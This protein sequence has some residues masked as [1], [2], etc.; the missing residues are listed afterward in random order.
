[1]FA[2]HEAVLAVCFPVARDRL[3]GLTHDGGLGHTS[4][5]A[6]ADGLAWLTRAGPPGT[7][8]SL[9]RLVR[10]SVLEPVPRADEMV[11]PLRWEAIGAGGPPFPVLDANL[12]L[13]RCPSERT[14]LVLTG[15]YRSPLGA[16]AAPLDRSVLGRAATATVRSLLARIAESLA[17]R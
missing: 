10:V 4:E 16:L 2:S 5:R 17:A 7:T 15:A 12:Q 1:M 11:L 8:L 6:Y 14:R 3:A 13:S 9:S